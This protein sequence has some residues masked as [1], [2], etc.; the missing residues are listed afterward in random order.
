MN[1]SM[2]LRSQTDNG[3]YLCPQDSIAEGCARGFDPHRQGR[4]TL[5][6]VR[7]KGALSA[8]LNRCPHLDVAM[9]YRKDR[10]MSANGQHIVCYA[11]GALFLP[12]SGVCVLGP[13]L[14]QSL[15]RQTI[16]VDAQGGVWLCTPSACDLMP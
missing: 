3:V 6:V 5:L 12:D 16:T 15:Q 9:Q 11:H 13:C 1:A 10:F 7:W 4:D 8:W 14:G 2:L